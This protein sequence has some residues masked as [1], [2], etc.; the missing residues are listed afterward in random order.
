MISGS[1]IRFSTISNVNNVPVL[2]LPT[3]TNV[4]NGDYVTIINECI[5]S[6]LGASIT[7]SNSEVNG[8]IYAGNPAN[9][10]S[11][12]SSS[13][14]IL[15]SAGCLTIYYINPNWYMASSRVA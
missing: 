7:L 1:V 14:H 3:T 4:N 13:T 10:F 5:N 8:K 6:T 15:Q 12:N 2:N 9:A 11:A